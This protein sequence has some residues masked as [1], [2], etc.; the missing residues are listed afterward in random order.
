M[1]EMLDDPHPPAP[2]PGSLHVVQRRARHLRR[3]RQAVVAAPAAA[4]VGT[5]AWLALQQRPAEQLEVVSVPISTTVPVFDHD[6][7]G[8]VLDLSPVPDG[9]VAGG[10]RLEQAPSAGSFLRAVHYIPADGSEGGLSLTRAEM[11]SERIE[12]SRS[13]EDRFALTPAGTEVGVRD[14]G[15][16]SVQV[17]EYI[18][19]NI[20][21]YLAVPPALADDALVLFDQV[22]FTPPE[23]R[24]IDGEVVLESASGCEQLAVRILADGTV[25]PL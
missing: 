2:P 4:A 17:T 8:E 23:P 1:F 9:W 13:A 10:E 14:V 3:R 19:Q 25:E 12:L 15:G 6:D 11:L 16:G 18:D 22:R 7:R 21:M 20:M 5:V 24:C